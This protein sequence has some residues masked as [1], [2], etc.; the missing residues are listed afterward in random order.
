MKWCTA[1][2]IYESEKLK[3]L[4]L[5]SALSPLVEYPL[6]KKLLY[7]EI[8]PTV[9]MKYYIAV[10]LPQIVRIWFEFYNFFYKPVLYLRWR[11]YA[12]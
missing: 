12:I 7:S 9:L 8:Y 1:T 6:G 4:L 10:Y 2:G 3:L 11:K 5:L